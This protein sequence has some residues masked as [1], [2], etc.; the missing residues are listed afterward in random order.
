M[1]RVEVNQRGK[2]LE[3]LNERKL[4][5]R[6]QQLS[7]KLLWPSESDYPWETI[8]L[9]NVDDLE[10][11]LLAII[12]SPAETKI[13][14]QELDR[15]FS[16]VTEEKDWY[17]EEEIAQCKGYQNLVAFLKNH[18]KDIKVYRVGEIEVNCYI[19]GKTESGAIAGLFTMSVET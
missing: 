15:F 2:K 12:D 18:L 16:R 8:A 14:I 13:E 11:K 5:E 1:L 10:A 6:L 7:E 17:N 4:T 3:L 9:E 19:L